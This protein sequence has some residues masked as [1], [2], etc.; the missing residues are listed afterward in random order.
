MKLIISDELKNIIPDYHVISYLITLEDDY[1]PMIKTKEVDE[2]LEDIYQTY[3]TKYQYD[4]I[5]NIPK[6][7]ETRDGYKKLGKDPSHTR[8]AA[9]SLLRRVIKGIKLYRIGDVVD[10]GNVLSLYTL[11]SVCVADADKII[12]DV[13]LKIGKKEDS[14][15]GIGRNLINVEN[16][17]IYVDDIS[18]FGSLTSDCDRTK[19]K[20]STKKLLVLI[21]SFTSNEINEDERLLIELFNKY[22]KCKEIIK[23]GE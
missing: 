17:P 12:G 7:K 13:Q 5:V 16:I 3:P 21:N 1:D 22:L 18:A 11:R 10:L 8:C 23:L 4:E 15:F 19:I 6:I 14:Y 9:E 2:L 20:Q